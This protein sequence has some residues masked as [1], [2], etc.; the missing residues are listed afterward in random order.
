MFI[1]TAFII[2]LNAYNI[3]TLTKAQFHIFYRSFTSFY[4]S[5]YTFVTAYNIVLFPNKS[6][7]A[8]DAADRRSQT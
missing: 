3:K 5:T 2:K 7:A 1:N 4:I 6:S 8:L